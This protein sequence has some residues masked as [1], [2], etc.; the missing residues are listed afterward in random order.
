MDQKQKNVLKRLEK[1]SEKEGNPYWIISHETGEFLKGLIRKHK[2]KKVLEVGTSIGY[3]GIWIASALR[4][5][6]GKLYTIESNDE[7]YDIAAANF[8]E[9]GV[10]DIIQQLKGHA[11]DVEI[12]DMIDLLF[13]DATKFEYKYYIST[14]LFHMKKG[15][16]IIADNAISHAEDLKDYRDYIFANKQL[17]SELLDI[18]TGL[19]I[20]EIVGDAS[21]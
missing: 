6:G 16:M 19:F 12:P 8:N 1:D 5:T 18:G 20:S 13:L 10:N 15:G 7:R 9:A 14:Y 4:K 11:P 21:K 17:K 2:F 3:S